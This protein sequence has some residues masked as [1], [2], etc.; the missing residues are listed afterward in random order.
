MYFPPLFLLL[1]IY[2]TRFNLPVTF[3]VF[4]VNAPHDFLRVTVMKVYVQIN[5]LN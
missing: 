1:N 3:Y 4:I 5:K 2:I